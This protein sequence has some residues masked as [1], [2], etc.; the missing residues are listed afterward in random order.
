M[1]TLF[2]KIM[3]V[4]RP[5]VFRVRN[6]MYGWVYP[7]L[8]GSPIFINIPRHG[9]EDPTYTYAHEC[10]HCVFPLSQTNFGSL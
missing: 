5:V 1:E 9:D 3:A 10:I 4:R 7:E 8:K 2:H 6:L